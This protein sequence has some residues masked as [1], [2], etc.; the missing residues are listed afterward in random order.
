MKMFYCLR[1]FAGDV[2][3]RTQQ[4][5]KERKRLLVQCR[6]GRGVRSTVDVTIVC[7]S[8]FFFVCL[9]GD[10]GNFIYSLVATS[11]GELQCA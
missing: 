4:K 6:I 8:K 2:T 7:Y 3:P 9:L 10:G 11:P 5:N 1:Y